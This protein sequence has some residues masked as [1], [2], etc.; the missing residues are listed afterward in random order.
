MVYFDPPY[1]IKYNSNFQPEVCNREVKDK[2]QEDLTREP[3]MVKAYRDT[4]RLGIHSYLAY[5]RDRLRAAKDLLH[6]TG[7]IFIQ[8]SDKNLSL[9]SLMA[10]EVFGRENKVQIITFTKKSHTQMTHSVA[11]YLLW[12][13]K[14][15]SAMKVNDLYR[16][17]GNPEDAKEYN[18][19]ELETGERVRANSLSEEDKEQ[20]RN[21]F[22]RINY[23]VVSQGVSE[24][25]TKPLVVEG[26][27]VSCGSNQW[28]YSEDGMK[29]LEK[30]G[31]LRPTKGSSAAGISYWG[32]FNLGAPTNIW[33]A[34]QGEH[35]RIYVVQTSWKVVERCL[36]MTTDP[37]DLVLDPTCGSGTTAYVAEKWGRRWIT[38]D[39]SRVTIALARKRL[40]TSA[41][42]F[43][44]LKQ[45]VLGVSG[46]FECQ[47]V[48]RI[49]LGAIARNKDLDLIFSKHEPVLKKELSACSRALS[50]VSDDLRNHFKVK[51]KKKGRNATDADE[52]M[53]NLPTAEVGFKHWTV[54]FKSDVDYPDALAQAVKH[55][56]QAWRQ[57][58]DEVN[59]CIQTN[60][61]QVELIDKPIV[62]RNTLRVSG[63]FT[64]EAF[65]PPETRPDKSSEGDGECA[66]RNSRAYTDHIINLLKKDGVRFPNNKQQTF[67]EL[68]LISGG[69]RVIHAQ[70]EWH[71]SSKAK[72]KINSRLVAVVCGPQ[73]GPVTAS[74]VK[75][76][77]QAAVEQKYSDLVIV[78][79]NFD[80]AAQTAI[81][82]PKNPVRVYMAHI[83]PDINPDMEN[84][85]KNPPSSQL[86]TVFG[87]PR[88]T[89]AG[90]DDDG[91]YV[92]EMEG[93]DIYNPVKNVVTSSNKDK[94]VAWLLDVDYDSRTFR[95]SQVFFS[96][97]EAWADIKRNLRGFVDDEAFSKLTG[98]KSFH[99]T[100]GPNRTVAVK[101]IDPRGNEVMSIH[102]LAKNK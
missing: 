53:W 73:Y 95:P 99:F 97:K 87:E 67:S 35:K 93:V 6:D 72:A 78:S 46:G 25:R 76:A 101:V 44:K 18:F 45:P 31:R 33:D 14:D 2:K 82:N 65:S 39:T 89:V 3:E 42:K 77:I 7:S 52:R 51:L 29:R 15:K 24:D 59:E 22:V 85:L 91:F 98:T 32:D 43:Y 54:P 86:F 19:V 96:S 63:P 9:V 41:F 57:R 71:A 37:G 83:S 21:R 84:L 100:P 8:I 55:Y 34:W 17:R 13:A 92:V 75:E 62:E 48:G 56:R 26:V 12:Y 47:T 28:R 4:W 102:K 69:S 68:T 27:T 20:Y 61:P 90:P 81:R 38:M 16:E 10:D 30:A 23:P 49:T 70:G 5:L 11:D 79:F 36:L 64:V 88:V 80:G 58:V 60:A 94:V 50:G 66:A 74:Q 1:G 40:L